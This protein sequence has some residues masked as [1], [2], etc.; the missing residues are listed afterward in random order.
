MALISVGFDD[1]GIEHF[2]RLRLSRQ[3][4]AGYAG[5][6]ESGIRD[7]ERRGLRRVVDDSGQSW[8]DPQDLEEW[9]WRKPL[10]ARSKR[11]SVLA[12]AAKARAY[13]ARLAALQREKRWAEEMRLEETRWAAERAEW[14][15]EDRLRGQVREANETAKREFLRNHIDQQAALTMLGLRSAEG[16]RLRCLVDAGLLRQ[17][18]PPCEITVV[19]GFGEAVR[20]EPGSFALLQGGPY[21]IREDVLRLRAEVAQV[22]SELTREGPDELRAARARG[23]PGEILRVFLNTR[24]SR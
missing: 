23:G 8:L 15:A 11:D 14:D 4:A 17:G 16:W 7:A 12:A 6:S 20:A 2:E 1:D 10:P 9:N 18:R 5:I 24:R 22:A 19:G 3:E 13:E 21:L